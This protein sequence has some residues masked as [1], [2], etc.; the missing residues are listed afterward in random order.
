[1]KLLIIKEFADANLYSEFVGALASALREL[2]HEAVVSD[3]SVHALNGVIPTGPLVA[4]LQTHQPD[5]VVSFRSMFGGVTLTNGASLFDALGVKFV[6]WQFD[7]PMYVPHALAKPLQGRYAI[8][9][10]RHHQRFADVLKT[11][12]RGMTLLPGGQAP[13]QPLKAHADRAWPVLVAATWQGAP[14]RAW[15]QAAEGPTKRLWMRSV[16]VLLADPQASVLDAVNTASK[17]IGLGIRLG[18][19]DA[20]DAAVLPM[21]REVLTYVRH[22][23]RIEI[24]K[25][26]VAAGLPV[27]LCG[28]GWDAILGDRPNLRYLAPVPFADLPALYGEARILLNLNAGNGGSERAVDGA[29]AGAAVVSDFGT[30]LER[31]FGRDGIAVFD[32]S[33]PAAV[34]Q[35]MAQLLESDEAE[36]LASRGHERAVEHGLWRR[37][38]E[39]IV[40]FVR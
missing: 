17:D 30:E 33:K 29:L 37:R 24:I 7:H 22:H 13:A 10:S 32:R 20:F 5:V 19:S 3:Q 18:Q 2:G 9:S 34:G 35:I 28:S 6:G 1:L 25:A 26:V 27:A 21:M 23:D 38:A 8:Y 39:Q 16:E 36:A 4:D 12:G 11:P 31:L 40:E 14:K 15:E